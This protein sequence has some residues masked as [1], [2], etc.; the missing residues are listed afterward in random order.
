MVPGTM[1][2]TSFTCFMAT[3]K[4]VKKVFDLVEKDQ[5]KLTILMQYRVSGSKIYL[6]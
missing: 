6:L 2:E 3:S 1:D 5:A 4:H